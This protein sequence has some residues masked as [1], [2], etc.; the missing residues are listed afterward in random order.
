MQYRK[1][2]NLGIEVSALG[3]GCMRFPTVP[4][5]DGKA[6]IDEP[7]AIRMLRTGIDAGINYIDTAY[8]Y[9]DGM[10]EIVVGKALQD[11]Y[12][13]RVYLATKSPSWFIKTAEDF[14]AKLDEQLEKLQ[15]D[16]IDFYLQHALNGETWKKFLELGIP[17]RLL[18]AKASGKVRHIGFSFHDS[19]DAF[20]FIVDS[21]DG[22]EF[23]QIML[24][25]IGVNDQAGV[26]GLEYAASK[27]LGVVI[28]EPLL[29]GKLAAL[30][31][32]VAERMPAGKSHVEW[33]LDW[34]WNRPEVSLLLSGMSSFQQVEDN[35]TY[36]ARSS[37]GMLSEREVEKLEQAARVYRSMA[38]VPCTKCRYCMPCPFGLDIPRIYEL[39]NETAWKNGVKEKYDALPVKADACKHCHACSKMCPQGIDPDQYMDKIAALFAQER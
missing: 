8:P 13:E 29:G 6:V 38:L 5:P 26:A 32:Q 10:S 34:L 30:S 16:H 1:F 15:T 9:H 27:G 24:N 35:L 20:K 22:W 11:G 36:A 12:R 17:D 4:G 18:A 33:A 37:V 23:C 28:M 19:L 25:Y 7:E 3:F 14:D 2:G 31:P 21:F 39:Y